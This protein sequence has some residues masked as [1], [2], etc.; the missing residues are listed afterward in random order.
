VSCGIGGHRWEA[1]R[2]CECVNHALYRG[3]MGSKGAQHTPHLKKQDFSKK[4]KTARTPDKKYIKFLL[5]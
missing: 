4:Q 3:I 2:L 1:A 5:M